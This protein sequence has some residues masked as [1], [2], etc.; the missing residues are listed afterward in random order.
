MNKKKTGIQEEASVMNRENQAFGET[1]R[2]GVWGFSKEW[3]R[4]IAL[5]GQLG[6]AKYRLT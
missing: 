6:P 1:N 4:A 3:K 5:V 2:N